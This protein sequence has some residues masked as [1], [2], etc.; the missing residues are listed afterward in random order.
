MGDDMGYSLL[1][2][3][4]PNYYKNIQHIEVDSS[5]MLSAAP[6]LVMWLVG[7][8]WA[9]IMDKLTANNTL[10]ILSVRRLSQAVA[11]YSP[12]LG[13]VGMCFVN[14]SSTLSVVVLCLVVGLNGTIISGHFCSHQDLAP[15]LAGTLLGLTN[16]GASLMGVVAPIFV[17][18]VTQNNTE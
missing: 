18:A 8:V 2:Y 4:M 13:L 5:G 7:L 15:N 1:L 16:T 3:Q 11:M 14:C 6:Y 12:G 17:G 10:S 9:A